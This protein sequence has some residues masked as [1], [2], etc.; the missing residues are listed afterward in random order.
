MNTECAIL[1]ATVPVSV[2]NI[3][4]A[5]NVI[6]QSVASAIP[7]LALVMECVKYLLTMANLAVVVSAVGKA[8]AVKH[9]LQHQC[10]GTPTF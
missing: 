5:Q 3:T 9:V 7:N 2:T 10:L 8:T 1:V 6:N 4:P